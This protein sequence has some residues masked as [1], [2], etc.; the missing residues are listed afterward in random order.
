MFKLTD[1]HTYVTVK[2]YI[3]RKRGFTL[4]ELLVVISIIA[5]L[6]SILMP[7]LGR[8]REQARST[9]CKSNLKQW[10][11]IFRYY[12]DDNNGRFM[13]WAPSGAGQGTWIY[14]LHSYYQDGG[15]EMRLCPATDRTPEEGETIPARMAWDTTIDDEYHKN[16]YSINN[17]CYNKNPNEDSNKIWG[18]QEADARAWRKNDQPHSSEIPMFLEGWR[19]GGGPSV[20]S[21]PA[22]PTDTER[23]N[24]GFG[25]YCLDRHNGGINI[26]FMDTSVR[27]VGLK[28]LWDLKWNKTYSFSIPLPEW[29]AWMQSLPD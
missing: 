22:P 1:G 9:V 24:T 7:A 12:T 17:W 20:R 21:D 2:N 19:W 25:R 18:L 27:Y 8:A 13:Q 3:G 4:I 26:C 29:P 14:S 23:H 11:L 10:G 5:L 6:V 16:S 15:Y 28:R